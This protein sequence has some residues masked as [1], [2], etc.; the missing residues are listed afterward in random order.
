MDSQRFW[1][2]P[3]IVSD[4]TAA[5]LDVLAPNRLLNATSWKAEGEWL[6]QFVIGD[7]AV[8]I[9]GSN[10]CSAALRLT[11][12]HPGTVARLVLCWPATPTRGETPDAMRGVADSEFED[13]AVPVVIIPA[14]PV[15]VHHQAE[16]VATL[17]RLIPRATLLPGSPEP[18]HPD[19]PAHRPRFVET[20]L[21]GL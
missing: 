19:F 18:P 7:P 10:G 5:G 12:D 14:E 2:D 15:N 6:R 9:A 21:S 11:L 4:L 20:L 17:T 1:S 16:T 13:I 8:V 3:G